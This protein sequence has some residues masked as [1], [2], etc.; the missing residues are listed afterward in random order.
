MLTSG[1]VLRS[2]KVAG[3]DGEAGMVNDIVFDVR[4]WRIASVIVRRRSLFARHSFPVPSGFL[5]AVNGSR[6]RL[7]FSLRTKAMRSTIAAAGSFLRWT[8]ADMPFLRRLVAPAL[9]DRPLF[10]DLSQGRRGIDAP[11]DQY[12]R[13]TEDLLGYCAQS[14]DGRIGL[15]EDVMVDVRRRAVRGLVIE[16]W[17]VLPGARIMVPVRHVMEI[18]DRQK[19]IWITAKRDERGEGSV[20]ELPVTRD[21]RDTGLRDAM[22]GLQWTDGA[23]RHRGAN[24]AS[25]YR[26]RFP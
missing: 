1:A 18:D 14:V 5:R 21:L 25:S 3:I 20:Y 12:R 24:R 16:L 7:L 4:S 19:K 6:R 23:P 13:L 22:A 11:A 8:S 2:W 15:V 10:V 17:T 26:I 9:D